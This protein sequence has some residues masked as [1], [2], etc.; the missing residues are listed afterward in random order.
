MKS[1]LISSTDDYFCSRTDQELKGLTTRLDIRPRPR[2]TID[3]Q[4]PLLKKKG[5]DPVRG[6]TVVAK[7]QVRIPEDGLVG[8]A[9]GLGEVEVDVWFVFF[10]FFLSRPLL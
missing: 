10:L 7:V 2:P 5:L 1:Q 9:V 8:F 3:P 6:Q 4:L